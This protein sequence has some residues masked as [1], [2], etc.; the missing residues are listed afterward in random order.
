[1]VD[2]GG[3]DIL[4]QKVEPLPSDVVDLSDFDKRYEDIFLPLLTSSGTKEAPMSY[5][6]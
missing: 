4:S 6:Q 3:D 5:L 2:A 1:M